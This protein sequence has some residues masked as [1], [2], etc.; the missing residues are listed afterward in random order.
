MS[1][2]S[3]IDILAA[4]EPE[5]RALL[6]RF[7]EHY[8]ESGAVPEEILHELFLRFQR[9]LDG[10]SQALGPLKHSHRPLKT[11]RESDQEELPVAWEIQKLIDAGTPKGTAITTIYQQQ[12][13]YDRRTIANFY[14]RSVPVLEMLRYL[15]EKQRLKT[16]KKT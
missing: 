8:K 3:R 2:L 16:G 14:S 13:R 12:H 15:E 1:V 11:S 5:G 10:D 6:I 9:M 4:E 7:C